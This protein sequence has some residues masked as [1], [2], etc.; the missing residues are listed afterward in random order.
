MS[1]WEIERN[2]L[3]N[4]I[5]EER[6]RYLLK[7]GVDPDFVVIPEHY[8]ALLAPQYEYLIGDT[9]DTYKGMQVIESKNCSIESVKVY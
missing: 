8:G 5:E 2:R 3:I 7:F 6:G 4:K 9:C 1:I